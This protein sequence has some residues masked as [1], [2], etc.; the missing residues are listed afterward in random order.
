M[1]NQNVP[2]WQKASW[3]A[4]CVQV[5]VVGFNLFFIS[6]QLRQQ[7]LQLAQQTVQ[8]DQQV[9]LNRAANTQALVN[10]VTPLNL[11]VTERG[12]AEL[13]LKGENGIDQI[14]DV[15]ERAIQMEQYQS[16]VVSY[17]VLYENAY[18][19]Y[20]NGLLD[21]EIYEGWDKDL[22]G[23]IEDHEIAKH[24]DQ[25]QDAYRKDFSDHVFEIIRRQKSLPARQPSSN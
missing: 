16:L 6:S 13:W 5:V 22:E 3:M 15:K 21:K 24:W 1:S 14:S 12:M 4:A 20:R 7:K 11:K 8:L 10:L 23:F 17:M 19:Q 25:W 9:K 18:S 2:F